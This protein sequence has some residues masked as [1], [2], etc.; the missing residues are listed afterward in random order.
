MVETADDFYLPDECWEDVFKFLIMDED[1][2]DNNNDNNHSQQFHRYL[3]F[4]SLSVVS[5]QFLSITN[6]LRF[7]ISIKGRELP[8]LPRL[9]ERF[10][11]LTS[12]ELRDYYDDDDDIHKYL[13]QLSGFS[14]NPTSLDLSYEPSI[15]AN[16]LQ[17]LSQ[18]ISTLTSLT[19]SFVNFHL[20]NANMFLIAHCFPNLQLLDLSYCYS[21]PDEGVGH[22]LNRCFNIRHLNLTYCY[23]VTLHG[24]NFEAPKLEVLNLLG[25]TM[26]DD[27]T[28][29]VISKTCRGL[30]QLNFERCYRITEKGV[31]LVV[32]NCTQLREI[33]LRGC[34]RMGVDVVESMVSSRPSLRKIIAPSRSHFPAKKKSFLQDGCLVC[35]D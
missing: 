34:I 31:K 25:S 8:F 28:L 29:D 12:L 1:D 33:N 24:M 11:N 15:P 32:E 30:L 13:D 26:V 14:L 19:C 22:V 4:K 27:E 21:V 2:D 5:K 7:S 16:G 35:F 18:N 17:A 3:E 6:R 23:G 10:T 20:N 9:F